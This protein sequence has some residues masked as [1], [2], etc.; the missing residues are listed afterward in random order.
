MHPKV[1]WESDYAEL[2]KKRGL[3]IQMI[4]DAGANIELSPAS[5][6]LAAFIPLSPLD[7]LWDETF[8]RIDRWTNH[9][10]SFEPDY[11]LCDKLQRHGISL[12]KGVDGCN[13]L[14][15]VLR[16]GCNFAS[17]SYLIR[18]GV[19]VHS[20]SRRNDLENDQEC[21]GDS[22]ML[23]DALIKVRV[24]RLKIVD[25][26]LE[27]GADLYAVTSKGISTLEAS[28]RSVSLDQ[29]RSEGII[30]EAQ[31][32]SRHIFWKLFRLMGPRHVSSLK[33]QQNSFLS[34]LNY[35]GESD[36]NIYAAL[37]A[38]IDINS[39]G[40]CSG[41]SLLMHAIF[42]SRTTLATKFL[43]RGCDVNLRIDS[44]P[45]HQQG[46]RADVNAP[47]TKCGMTALQIAAAT[48]DLGIATVLLEKGADVNAK[49]G[50]HF[51][52]NISDKRKLVY[53][54][55][56]QHAVDFAAGA[57]HLDMVQLLVDA[58]GL[59][60]NPGVT[61]L[62]GG[63]FEARQE[64]HNGVVEYLQQHTGHQFSE[65]MYQALRAPS[66]Q[67]S[68]ITGHRV[69]ELELPSTGSECT[70]GERSCRCQP[71]VYGIGDQGNGPAE[72]IPAAQVLSMAP[73]SQSPTSGPIAH[74]TGPGPTN[75]DPIVA[76][77]YGTATED[78]HIRDPM[79]RGE[80]ENASTG[81]LTQFQ[82]NLDHI[83]ANGQ[84][85]NGQTH[86]IGIDSK[87]GMSPMTRGILEW[88]EES[89][90][91]VYPS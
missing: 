18:N 88:I 12:N 60:A 55:K 65:E 79:Q 5:L 66:P 76:P 41:Y 29:P 2:E 4:L 49:T 42:L 83:E 30:D 43:E 44:F 82:G 75:A 7:K 15:T 59:S 21:I 89:D 64:G 73:Q 67:A 48:G 22:T 32:E 45:P 25:L 24:D 90:F 10:A 91:D 3:T 36:D 31:Q 51:D 52:D 71:V 35:L 57:G 28:L 40:V 39:Y 70:D 26:L 34:Y 81:E 50:S 47:P 74:T 23:H 85:W 87:E 20:F 38:V 77:L 19:Q 13:T 68:V 63:M 53:R 16:K 54:K 78:P 17:V 8:E 61:G 33:F 58:G 9:I 56:D 72:E 11:A 69:D 37:D 14:Q 62:D 27:N 80:A 1:E 84:N 86:E 46:L 6:M